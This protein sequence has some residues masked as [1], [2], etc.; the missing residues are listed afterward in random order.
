M[1]LADAIR[2]A[3]HRASFAPP[4]KFQQGPESGAWRGEQDSFIKTGGKPE[5]LPSEAQSS[6]WD[7]KIAG[8]GPRLVRFE[9]F[10]DPEQ[11]SELLYRLVQS[12]HPIMT[13]R[14]AAHYLRLKPPQLHLLAE[15]GQIPAFQI[16]GKWRFLKTALDEWMLMQKASSFETAP[17]SEG[18]VRNVP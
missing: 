14:E 16:D 15:S 6:E 11:L 13:L 8:F 2:A 4:E 10:L 3:T 12:L 17:Q 7:A 9:C 1:N 18:E 5:S